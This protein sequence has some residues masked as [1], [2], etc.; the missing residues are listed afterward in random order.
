[1][2]RLH[3]LRLL[4]QQRCA[5]AYKRHRCR[6][7]GAGRRRRLLRTGVSAGALLQR[8]RV[9]LEP[10]SRE[11]HGD[12]SR[13]RGT[14]ARHPQH[15]HRRHGRP[16]AGARGAPTNCALSTRAGS[17]STRS[18]CSTSLRS[19]TSWRRSA[20]TSRSIS[21]AMRRR[22]TTR[23]RY[24]SR[25]ELHAT[26][27]A[28][29]CACSAACHGLKSSTSFGPATCSSCSPISRGSRCQLIEAMAA[30]C[31]PVVA[32]MESGISEVLVP[33][34]SGVIVHWPELRAMGAH[35]SGSL[36]RRGAPRCNG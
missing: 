8:N 25:N 22:P 6:D 24:S 34:E 5:G 13:D 1:M 29:R 36:A 2:H 12:P 26:S 21:S 11:G 30:G 14:C 28:A 23:R 17:S 35:D 33:D 18:A 15:E 4:R 16:S 32:E 3:H 27:N 10:D 9:R 31:V 7:V 19:P 20:S